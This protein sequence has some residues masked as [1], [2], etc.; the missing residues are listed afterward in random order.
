MERQK[1]S[2]KELADRV[3][4]TIRTDNFGRDMIQACTEALEENPEVYV[5]RFM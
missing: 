4:A 5:P 3:Y 2:E 1:S